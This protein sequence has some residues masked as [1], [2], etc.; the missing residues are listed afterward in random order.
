MKTIEE[1]IISLSKQIVEIELRRDAAMLEALI[2]DD[3]VGVDPSGILIDKTISV[4]RYRNADFELFQHAVDEISVSVLG[5]V[6]IEIGVM[7]LA[8]RLGSFEFGGKYRYTHT[9]LLTDSGWK[10]RASQLTP[11]LRNA[12]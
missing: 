1:Q 12:A 10:V 6:A 8:G 9:W 4:G 7:T 2:C 3:Y 5:S 11:I